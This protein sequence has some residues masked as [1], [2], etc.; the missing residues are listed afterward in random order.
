MDGGRLIFII[1]DHRNDDTVRDGRD[2]LSRSRRDKWRHNG[3][4]QTE[5]RGDGQARLGGVSLVEW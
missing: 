3:T 1:I 2:R 5:E 4:D